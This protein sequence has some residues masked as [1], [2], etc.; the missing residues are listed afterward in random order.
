MGEIRMKDGGQVSAARP[1]QKRYWWRYLLVWF[2]GVISCIGLIVGGVLITGMVMK[3]RD[4]MYMVGLDPNQYIGVEYQDKTILQT[5]TTLANKSFDTL[6]DLNQVSP[7]VQTL[8]EKLNDEYVEPT[9]S[10]RFDWEKTKN[11]PFEKKDEYAQKVGYEVDTTTTLG[12]YLADTAFTEVKIAN[13]INIADSPQKKILELFLYDVQRDEDGKVVRDSNGDPVLGE[14]YSLKDFMNQKSGGSSSTSS[15]PVIDADDV[16]DNDF[17]QHIVDNVFDCA[18][19]SYFGNKIDESDVVISI[20]KDLTFREIFDGALNDL[21]VGQ[22]VGD[23]GSNHLLSKLFAMTISELNDFNFADA[24]FSQLLFIQY[25]YVLD[26]SGHPVLY[27]GPGIPTPVYNEKGLEISKDDVS[28]LFLRTLGTFKTNQLAD[29]D[30]ISNMKINQFIEIDPSSPIAMRTLGNFSFNQIAADGFL[31]GLYF[32]ELFDIITDPADPKYNPLMNTLSTYKLGDIK[33]NSTFK[34]FSVSDLFSREEYVDNKLITALLDLD[35][36]EKAAGRVGVTLGNI[37]EMINKITIGNFM[38]IGDDPTPL[39]RTIASKTLTDIPNLINTLTV[40]DVMD[41]EVGS[42]YVNSDNNKI[43]FKN[44]N[45][46][47]S[48]LDASQPGLSD[49]EIAKIHRDLEIYDDLKNHTGEFEGYEASFY[50]DRLLSGSGVPSS[51]IGIS[52][53]TLFEIRNIKISDPG[54]FI[55][56]IKLKMKLG[57]LVEIDSS[58]PLVLQKLENCTLDE[59]PAK[60]ATFSLQDVIPVASPGEEGYS[61]F[62]Y[63]LRNA[64]LFDSEDPLYITK[65]IDTLTLGDVLDITD[66]SPTILQTLESYLITGNGTTS[67]SGIDVMSFKFNELMTYE[68]VEEQNDELLTELW[69]DPATG[70]DFTVSQLPQRVKNIKLTTL[71]G[72][73]LYLNPEA[74]E[75]NRRLSTTWWFLFTSEEDY[76]NPGG[77]NETG[78]DAGHYYKNLLSGKEYTSNNLVNLVTNLSYHMQNEKLKDLEEA[79]LITTGIDL[80]Q[81][82]TVTIGSVPY[83]VTTLPAGEY[84]IQELFAFFN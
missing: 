12:E 52:R 24:T 17:F 4:V 25:P 80:T 45:G 50:S 19:L 23:D 46:N 82:L 77:Y 73:D 79:G 37:S 3:T 53:G 65:V 74:S 1:K 34:S 83:Q 7:M 11:K 84:T 47:W 10:F 13:F 39:M 35:E 28:P 51:E 27:T 20:I 81:P 57:A 21:T 30:F 49:S 59:V 70:G 71:I 2:S 54:N 62:L 41:V 26:S 55:D 69:G 22:F 32:W 29:S 58:S 6:E 67:L 8:F 16:G 33:K 76:T 42:Y 43:Y 66:S 75:E 72:S 5:V 9:L 61:K 31:D 56:E 63:S 14:P 40:K 68:Q 38:Y 64:V 60:L 36:E 18:T 48:L 78:L 44:E 15:A